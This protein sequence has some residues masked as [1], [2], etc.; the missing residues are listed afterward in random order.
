MILSVQAENKMRTALLPKLMMHQLA[1]NNNKNNDYI[2]EA[3]IERHVGF[4]IMGT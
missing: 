4:Q 3:N 1:L 2:R